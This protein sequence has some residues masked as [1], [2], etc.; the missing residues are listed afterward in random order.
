MERRRTEIDAFAEAV[1]DTLIDRHPELRVELGRPGD[2]TAYRDFSPDGLAQRRIDASGALH[3][4]GQ[5]TPA[6]DVDRVTV[7]EL[8]RTL[9]LEIDSLDAG[10]PYRDLNNIASPVQEIRMVLDLMPNDSEDDQGAIAGRMANIP[11]ALAGYRDTLRTGVHRGIVP[12]RR[13]VLEAAAQCTEY[14]RPGGYFDTLAHQ[15]YC[16]P[17]TVALATGAAAARKAYGEFAD[18][19]TGEL[20]A[21][22]AIDDAVG[23][24]QYQLVSRGFLGAVVDLDEAYEW[25]L[26]EVDRMRAEQEAVAN[27]ILPGATVAE[28][29]AHINADP[30]RQVHG[31]EA[32]QQWMQQVSDR[33]VAEL[34]DTHFDIPEPMRRLECRIAPTQEGGIYYTGP[35]EDFTRPGRMWW[36]VPPGETT[37]DI[38]RELTTVYHEGVPG[39]H[40]QI[41]TAT[42]CKDQLNS[43][44]R[45][46]GTSGHAEGWALYAERL[47]EQLG[48]LDDPAHRLG[49]LD[50][51]R[52]RAARVVVDL[53]LHLGKQV[54][55]ED[56][57]WTFDEVLAFMRR[58]SSMSDAT[59]HFEVTRYCGWPG[60][61]PSYKLGQRIWE[62]LRAEAE[63]RA[64]FDLKTWHTR[65]LSL[66]GLGLD[67]LREALR[68]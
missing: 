22:A 27:E 18:F 28:A 52:M 9:C 17:V 13:Q 49:M 65:A 54:P 40:L 24:E 38:W 58:H 34:A 46:N 56:H 39:H 4:L 33:A 15:D 29:I 35:S 26:A 62:E 32:L 67:T 37:F 48:H 47:M 63:Q 2:Q 53:G 3:R 31:T 5:L 19:L 42:W 50:E 43:W 60:Q 23:R 59:L 16:A 66:G 41:A 21:V 55:G 61:A 8:R 11:A 25:G 20:A 57:R 64:D 10:L 12:A 1:L 36:S 30:A 7:A 44:R 45:A 14:A 6:D 51:Q 68:D